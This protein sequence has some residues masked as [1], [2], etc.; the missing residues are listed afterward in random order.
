[1]AFSLIQTT[2]VGAPVE[3]YGVNHACTHTFPHTAMQNGSYGVHPFVQGL[4]AVSRDFLLESSGLYGQSYLREMKIR[5]KKDTNTSSKGEIE[6]NTE[7]VFYLFRDHFAEGV[8]AYYSIQLQRLLLLVLTWE[9]GVVYVVDY[10]T[11]GCLGIFR[12]DGIEGWGFVS[13]FDLALYSTVQEA[14]QRAAAAA[15]GAAET[16]SITEVSS[17]NSTATAAAAAEADEKAAREQLM[18]HA[19]EQHLW[20]TTGGPELLELPA[21]LIEAALAANLPD[22]SAEIKHLQLEQRDKQQQMIEIWPSRAC[23]RT[24]GTLNVKRAAI[25]HCLGHVL[26]GLNEMEYNKQRN[27]L[28]ANL[29]GLP[30]LVEIDPKTG[31]CRSLIS[32]SGVA[33]VEKVS[34]SC[35]YLHLYH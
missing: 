6:L 17:P 20:I 32:L 10:E 7:R 9:S 4:Q 31:A 1:M 35:V 19:K 8:A 5:I 14:K 29:Y 21:R 2:A 34:L 26:V 15:A 28:L 12:A 16:S 23:K 13:S 22:L 30:V 27:T 18:Q 24:I 3:L 25:V 11:F 33:I